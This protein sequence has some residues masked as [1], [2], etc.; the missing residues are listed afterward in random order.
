MLYFS[1]NAVYIIT[2]LFE[3][4]GVH[5]SLKVSEENTYVTQVI[6]HSNN[7]GYFW[8]IIFGLIIINLANL[9]LG[10]LTPKFIWLGLIFYLALVTLGFILRNFAY[11]GIVIHYQNK[12]MANAQKMDSLAEINKLKK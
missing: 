3:W 8:S 1:S 11:S 6:K 2:E 12:T 5:T 9:I 4:W 10:L 7:I